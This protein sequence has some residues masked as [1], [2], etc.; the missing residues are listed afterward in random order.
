MRSVATP[1][2]SN[3]IADVSVRL[4]ALVVVATVAVA[5]AL[6]Q[7]STVAPAEAAVARA[8]AAPCPGSTSPPGGDTRYSVSRYSIQVYVIDQRGCVLMVQDKE[9]LQL[10]D[11]QQIVDACP[12]LVGCGFKNWLHGDIPAGSADSPEF[13][14]VSLTLWIRKARYRDWK[15]GRIFGTCK[16]STRFPIRFQNPGRKNF[17][18]Y[19]CTP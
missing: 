14:H 12:P 18:R 4:R 2:K 9:I 11:G 5:A 16:T 6:T 19:R 3:L 17:I 13:A 8:Q 1:R 7:V 15:T 10:A